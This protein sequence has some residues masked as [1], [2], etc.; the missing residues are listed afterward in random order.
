MPQNLCLRAGHNPTTRIKAILLAALLGLMG[1]MMVA[2]GASSIAGDWAPVGETTATLHFSSNGDFS[3]PH[4]DWDADSITRAAHWEIGDGG[5]IIFTTSYGDTTATYLPA[6]SK[7]IDWM[8]GY[9]YYLSGNTLII[10]G[11]EFVRIR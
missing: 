1:L 3:G 7:D 5:A 11:D 8:D 9:H 10:D 6:K 4:G 2:C